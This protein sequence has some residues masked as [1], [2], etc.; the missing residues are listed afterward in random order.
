MTALT[1][2]TSRSTH[3]PQRDRARSQAFRYAMRELRGGLRGFYVFVACIALGVFAI[4]R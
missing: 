1:S 2:D 3:S 4:V